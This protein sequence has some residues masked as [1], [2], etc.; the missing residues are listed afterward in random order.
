MVKFSISLLFLLQSMLAIGEVLS[1]T[2]YSEKG[3]VMPYVNVSVENTDLRAVTNLDGYYSLT[4]PT[5][6]Y[7]ISFSYLGYEILTEKISVLNEDII[8]DV[9][10]IKNGVSLSEATVSDSRDRAKAIMRKARDARKSHLLSISDFS[11]D[12]YQLIKLSRDLKRASKADSAN[13]NLFLQDSIKTNPFSTEILEINERAG[14][15]YFKDSKG[16]KE[17]ISGYRMFE[18][19]DIPEEIGRS[20][21]TGSGMEFGENIITPQYFSPENPWI[22]IKGADLLE[23][24]IYEN[25]IYFPALTEKPI[26]SPLAPTSALNYQFDF[27][28]TDSLNN[29]NCEVIKLTPINKLENLFT[30]SVW[31]NPEDYSIVKYDLDI[32][33]GQLNYA[34][35]FHI[36]SDYSFG[37]TSPVLQRATYRI[38]DGR[39]VVTGNVLTEYSNYELNTGLENIDFNREIKVF[40]TEAFDQKEEFWKSKRAVKLDSATTSFITEADSIAEYLESD[41]YLQRI[42]SAF[43]RIDIWT[44]LIGYGRRNRVKGNEFYIEGLLGQ[45]IPL[46]IGGYR[47]RLPG[48][49]EK[50]FK[51]DFSIRTSGFLDYGFT[52][53][54]LKGKLILGFTYNPKKFVRTQIKLGDYYDMV[55]DFASLEQTFSRSNFIRT[56]ELG[57]SQRMEVI[58]G[59][60]AE[61]SFEYQDQLPLK[62][63]TFSEWSTD[64]FGELNTPIDFDRYIKTEVRLQVEYR[65]KQKFYFRK[66]RKMVIPSKLPILTMVYRKGINRL[67]NSEVDFDYLEIGAHQEIEL[68]RLGSTRWEL[69][70]GSFLNQND[71]RVLEYKFFRGS[72]QLVFSDPLRS[73]QLLGPTLNTPNE[74]LRANV[75]HHF[76]G[77]VLNKIP[78]IR[79]LKMGLA[80]GGG[81]LNIPDSDFYHGE[82]YAGVEKS[83]RIKKQLL[84]AGVYAVVADNTFENPAPTYKVGLTFYDTFTRKWGY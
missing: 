18:N 35:S 4:L 10:L 73:F 7:E 6:K 67:F 72:D 31:F 75:I 74:Y 69:N 15:L 84:R 16:F 77:T 9:A 12:Y 1:G 55:N 33:G 53:R 66:N 65:I 42:D 13:Y 32:E 39:A 70:L 19:N 34:F 71:L 63:L 45:V 2:V 36:E 68:G 59:L 81:T 28:G 46:G 47:H 80:V 11:A 58:N 40:E 14:E 56:K 57:I 54:D 50:R 23:L 44:P 22:L 5:G 62:E 3:T 24:N 76:E 51:N 25:L 21:S 49:F 38:K 60:Y 20:V 30:G 61:L 17:N 43:N 82:V 64:L 83:F 79:R 78:L 8:L 26:L 37:I 41:E 52:N 27:I 48:Y 29:I